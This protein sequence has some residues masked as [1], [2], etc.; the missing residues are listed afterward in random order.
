VAVLERERIERRVFRGEENID[1][2]TKLGGVIPGEMGEED[3][4]VVN[5]PP[6]SNPAF[7]HVVFSMFI[8]GF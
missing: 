8:F 6:S 1:P 7:V 3:Y 5:P 2:T 4:L